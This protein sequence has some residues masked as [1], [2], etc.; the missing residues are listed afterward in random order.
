MLW[1]RMLVRSVL[2]FSNCKLI[3]RLNRTMFRVLA[4]EYFWK[5][6]S[7]ALFWVNLFNEALCGLFYK[8]ICSILLEFTCLTYHLWKYVI[9]IKLVVLFLSFIFMFCYL[10]VIVIKYIYNL[11]F[12]MIRLFYLPYILINIF[13]AMNN[14]LIWFLLAIFWISFRD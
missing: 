7:L 12:I 2:C 11:A 6:R 13:V 8:E 1:I 3:L 4:L 10:I 9:I 5:G 14:S